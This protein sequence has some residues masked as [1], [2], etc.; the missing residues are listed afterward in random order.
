LA[1]RSR[2][3][4]SGMIVKPIMRFLKLCEPLADVVEI[5]IRKADGGIH[6]M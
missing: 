6:S 4:D 5:A 2:R 3:T 1:R